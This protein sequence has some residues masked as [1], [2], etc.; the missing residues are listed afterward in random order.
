MKNI[1]KLNFFQK[2]M[3]LRFHQGDIPAYRKPLVMAY[4]E[5]GLY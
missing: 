5:W 2:Y 3:Y 1:L 4:L